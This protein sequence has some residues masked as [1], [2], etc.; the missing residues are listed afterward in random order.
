MENPEARPSHAVP[1][2]FSQN[3]SGSEAIR[4]REK[5]EDLG[6]IPRN[7]SYRREECPANF[8]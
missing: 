3:Y 4:G 1:R 6:P 2:G 8:F 7:R 5:D